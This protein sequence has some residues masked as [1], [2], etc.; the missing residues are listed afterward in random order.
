M[1]E[2]NTHQAQ[3]LLERAKQLVATFKYPEALAICEQIYCFFEQEKQWDK[4][5]HVLN[6]QSN[7]LWCSGNNNKGLNIALNV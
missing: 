6:I 4:C 5:V 3:Q 7:C 2:L 1:Q